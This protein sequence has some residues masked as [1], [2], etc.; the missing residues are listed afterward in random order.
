MTL[1]HHQPLDRIII[2]LK[3]EIKIRIKTN[4]ELDFQIQQD[5]YPHRYSA[6]TGLQF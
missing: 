2:K 3:S 6:V 1:H 4:A 5:F